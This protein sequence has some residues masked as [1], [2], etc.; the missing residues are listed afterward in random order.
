GRSRRD[1]PPDLEDDQRRSV[2]EQRHVAEREP[3]PAPRVGLAAD[4]RHGRAALAAEREE[5]HHREGDRQR[6]ER[7]A[8]VAT[9][10]GQRPLEPLRIVLRVAEAEDRAERRDDDLARRERGERR[11]RDAPVP[12]E[13]PE[14]RLERVADAAERAL[15]ELRGALRDFGG[16]RRGRRGGGRRGRGGGRPRGG[17][18][19]APTG[20]GG[21]EGAP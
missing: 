20:G 17:G 18:G 7:R 6:E 12:A 8:V 10:A 2:R 11:D 13:R 21:G 19:R 4:R 16:G 3:R 9:R 1:R 14:D 15:L 5:D